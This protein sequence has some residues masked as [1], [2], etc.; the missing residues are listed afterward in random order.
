M[1]RSTRLFSN[2]LPFLNLANVFFENLKNEPLSEDLVDKE[3][4]CAIAIH[5]NNIISS[6]DFQEAQRLIDLS[7]ETEVPR[8]RKYVADVPSLER[9]AKQ[10]R[11]AS[12]ASR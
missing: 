2:S 4:Q 9:E 8:K 7:L 10:R 1:S 12:Y 11:H 3:S 6:E 5:L